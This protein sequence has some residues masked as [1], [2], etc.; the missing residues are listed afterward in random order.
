MDSGTDSC[1]GCGWNASVVSVCGEITSATHI[2]FLS[3]IANQ[4]I[5]PVVLF[6]EVL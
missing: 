1:V 4:Y 2:V 6:T 5:H 3:N